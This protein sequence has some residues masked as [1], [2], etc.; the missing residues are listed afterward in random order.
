MGPRQHPRGQGRRIA[1]GLEH[2]GSALS[3]ELVRQLYPANEAAQ[4]RWWIAKLDWLDH[5]KIE[6]LVAALGKLANSSTNPELA[7]TIRIEAEY[8]EGNQERMRYPTFRQKN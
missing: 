8:F 3:G 6:K 1:P 5:G 2:R 7:K 4:K